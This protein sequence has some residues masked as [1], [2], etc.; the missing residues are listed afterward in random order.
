MSKD[1]IEGWE[2]SSKEV[3]RESKKVG[4]PKDIL[5]P[6]VIIV[7][8][9]SEESLKGGP[10]LHLDTSGLSPSG[11]FITIPERMLE[12]EGDEFST[13]WNVKEDIRHELI[14]YL[15]RSK[16]GTSTGRE[17]T[18]L[19]EAKK[20]VRAE[21]GSR[22]KSLPFNLARL[23]YNLEGDYSL[24]KEEAFGI[25][26]EAALDSGVSKQSIGRARSMYKDHFEGLKVR[27]EGK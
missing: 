19:E 7:G 4:I 12:K 26:S 21:V 27:R 8:K 15:E 6:E 3:R 1:V 10:Q 16:S 9:D 2:L 22:P 24:S 5:L 13:P 11:F 25:M 20:E 17:Q 18:P 14:H 23:A